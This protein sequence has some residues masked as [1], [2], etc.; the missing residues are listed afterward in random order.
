LIEDLIAAKKILAE[1]KVWLLEFIRT[2]GKDSKFQL[3][4]QRLTEA[5]SNLIDNAIFFTNEGKVSAS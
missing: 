4:G 3:D 2:E 5:I 1:N